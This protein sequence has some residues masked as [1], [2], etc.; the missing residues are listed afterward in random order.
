MIEKL[1]IFKQMDWMLMVEDK[2]M[3]PPHPHTTTPIQR[4]PLP[5]IFI[6]LC[7]T[8]QLTLFPWPGLVP[9]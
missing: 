4:D 2:Y 6:H 9:Y 8:N 7:S 3:E 1:V 5:P